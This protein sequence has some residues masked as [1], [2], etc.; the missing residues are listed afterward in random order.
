MWS[1]T[2]IIFRG[3]KKKKAIKQRALWAITC[4]AAVTPQYELRVQTHSQ[5]STGKCG[6][7]QRQVTRI[8]RGWNRIWSNIWEN[9]TMKNGARRVC[10][11]IILKTKYLRKKVPACTLTGTCITK[12]PNPDPY[13]RSFL[14]SLY[15]FKTGW[16]MHNTLLFIELGLGKVK[17]VWYKLA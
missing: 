16:E 8:M 15:Q 17:L 4:T 12:Q 1:Q 9:S 5:S 6:M 3:K 13:H 7:I 10:P 11:F 14:F 2:P